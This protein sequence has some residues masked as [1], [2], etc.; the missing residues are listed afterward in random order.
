MSAYQE[1]GSRQ[2]RSKSLG[3]VAQEPQDETVMR[4]AVVCVRNVERV[5]SPERPAPPGGL[6]QSPL[7]VEKLPDLLN[8]PARQRG[9]AIGRLL[10]EGGGLEKS[11]GT[12]S[13]GGL[14]LCHLTP[15]PHAR[16]KDE[17]GVLDQFWCEPFRPVRLGEGMPAVPFLESIANVRADARSLPGPHSC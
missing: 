3:P 8:A 6:Q 4:R 1:T 11:E 10:G 17:R 9:A 5:V 13:R 2:S 15:L 16:R 12:G 7:C 14:Q